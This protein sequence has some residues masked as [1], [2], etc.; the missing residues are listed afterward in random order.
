MN[1]YSNRKADT[2]YIEA[3]RATDHGTRCFLEQLDWRTIPWALDPNHKSPHDHLIDFACALP[4]FLEDRKRLKI[5]RL[6][7]FADSKS[8]SK[9]KASKVTTFESPPSAIDRDRAPRTR[10]EYH[11]SVAALCGRISENVRALQ[12]WKA[13]WNEASPTGV[14]I[15]SGLDL[16]SSQPAPY[17]LPSDL[18]GTAL[19]FSDLHRANTYTLYS[20]ILFHLLGILIEV[21]HGWL[22]PNASANVT[23][24]SLPTA[25]VSPSQSADVPKDLTRQR[26]EAALEICR[27]VPYHLWFEK[28]GSAGAYLMMWPLMSALQLFTPPWTEL[29]TPEARWIKGVLRH[30]A[31]RWGLGSM[32]LADEE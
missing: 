9:L 21:R 25:Y 17:D 1:D 31:E 15:R 26:C 14:P 13:S 10:Q 20:M 28:H 32:F 30:I 27:A 11:S 5:A 2:D 18:F 6:A 7:D 22:S 8:T 4:G 29:P 19:Q 16:V 12:K 3:A 23:S 24:A